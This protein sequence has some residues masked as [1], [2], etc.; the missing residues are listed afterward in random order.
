MRLNVACLVFAISV[1]L[2]VALS[3]DA[4][5]TVT[6][7]DAPRQW[8]ATAVSELKSYLATAVPSA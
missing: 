1:V 2:G 3:S 4:A 8:E 7:P 5:V 6:G